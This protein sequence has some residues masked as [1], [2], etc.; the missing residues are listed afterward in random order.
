MCV[1]EVRVMLGLKVTGVRGG[2]VRGWGWGFELGVTGYDLGFK[3]RLGLRLALRV[4]VRVWV[5]G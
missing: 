5:R 2:R 3:L 1:N 4:M